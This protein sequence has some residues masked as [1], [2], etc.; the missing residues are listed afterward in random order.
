MPLGAFARVDGQSIDMVGLVASLDG[1][2][3]IRA[4]ARGNRGGAAA[5]GEKLAGRLLD[6]G[7]ATVLEQAQRRS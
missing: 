6:K 2:T 5:V 3:L 1:R 4:T 7:A